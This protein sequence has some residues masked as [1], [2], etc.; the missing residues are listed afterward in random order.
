[1]AHSIRDHLYAIC[2]L[3]GLIALIP[4]F[5]WLRAAVT[6]EQHLGA[7]TLCVV[8]AVFLYGAF[9]LNPENAIRDLRR[10]EKS[11]ASTSKEPGRDT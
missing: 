4:G 11:G 3:I 8:G 5:I 1:M 10:R 9:R 6:L 2:I 7:L